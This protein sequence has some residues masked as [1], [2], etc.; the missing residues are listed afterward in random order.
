MPLKLKSDVNCCPQC[1]AP[2]SGADQ[3]LIETRVVDR[4]A[5]CEARARLQPV[6][7]IE[8]L[9]L[10]NWVGRETLESTSALLMSAWLLADIL[11]ET[12]PC[13]APAFRASASRITD[14]ARE[15]QLLAEK[16]VAAIT[17]AQNLPTAG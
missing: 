15:C 14:E 7:L 11:G 3:L 5:R 13:P 8:A 10:L 12:K 2:I 9:R 4:C 17:T 16:L 6:N 1:R